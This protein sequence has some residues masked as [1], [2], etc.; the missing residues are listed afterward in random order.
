[1]TLRRALVFFEIDV[2]YCANTY[3]SAPCTASVPTT[4]ARKC[5]NSLGTCQDRGN[6]TNSP[7]TLRFAKDTDYLP[8]DIDI[9]SP[10]IVDVSFSAGT[11]SLG[12]DLGQRTSLT[13]KFKDHPHA[14]TGAGF[15]KYL[16]DRPY[17]PFKQGTFWG[18]FKARNP[19]LRGRACRLIMGFLGQSLAEMETRHFVMDSFSGPTQEGEFTIIAKDVLKLAD[20]ER[21]QAPKF[22][23]GTLAADISS[24]ASSL[25]VNPAGVGMTDYKASG[26]VAIGGK[27]IVAFTRG[28]T[29]NDANAQ[30]LLHFDGSN[31][32]TSTTDSSA[33]ARTMTRNGSAVLG[34]AQAKFGTASGEFPGT[35]GSHWSAADAAAWTFGGN[36]TLECHQRP[37]TLAADRTLLCHSTDINNMY[38]LYVTTTGRLRFEIVVSGVVTFSIQSATGIIVAATWAHVALVRN[39][40][41]WFLFKDGAIVATAN[42]SVSITNFTSTFKIGASGNGTSDLMLGYID[43]VRVSSIARWTAAFTVPDAQYVANGDVFT[44]TRAQF[45]TTA[46]AHSTEDRVQMCVAYSAKDPAEI[47]Y[48]LL[49]NY[50]DVPTAFLP[51]A[52]WQTESANYLG[53]VYTACIPYPV[54]VR[55]LLC[56]LIQQTASAMWWSDLDKQIRWQILRKIPAGAETYNEDVISEGTLNIEEQPD[57]RVSQCQVYFGQ[58]NALEPLEREDNYINSSL[59]ISLQTETDYGSPVIKTIFSRWIPRLG[60]AIAQRVGTI[61]LSRYEVPP[62]KATFELWRAEGFNRPILG[63]GAN[64]E[65]RTLQDDTGARLAAPIQI[66]RITPQLDRWMVEAE[67]ALF[68]AEELD[69]NNRIVP[70]DASG[71][72]L[73]LRTLHDSIYPVITNGTG[74]TVTCVIA[75]TVEIG[76]NSISLPAFDVGSWAA[77]PP[78]IILQVRG[79]VQGKGGQGLNATTSSSLAN[80]GTALKTR[81]AIQLDALGGKVWGGGGG[82][83]GFGFGG[84]GGAGNAVGGGAANSFGGGTPG[85]AGSKTA[86]G[87]GGTSNNIN[88]QGGTGGGPGL[89]GGS[90]F[91]PVGGTNTPGGSAGNAIDGISYVTVTQAGD[92][93][94]PEIN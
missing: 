65:D 33:N 21:S 34:T 84:G 15:D 83:G 1:M 70:I 41:D 39:G 44:I 5:F 93:R 79:T 53:R 7:V 75:S 52:D 43:E 2:D 18:K 71:F 50:A 66:T 24:G 60:K 19:Y 6:F 94:G 82:G 31:G 20:D 12:E 76:S 9:T 49:A 38:R 45:G 47:I 86:G 90:S 61:V 22:S 69:L 36:F 32:A 81:V 42:N 28:W 29:G 85:G 67:E 23:S 46:I 63:G 35:G 37:T 14:D 64:L 87:P 48:D 55:T 17:N 8:K 30:L 59:S 56:E 88:G 78:T 16:S 74:I 10:S 89:A 57:K 4:G 51:L 72:N 80:G 68:S 92:R 26:Y 54:G 3:G 40:N 73:N 58:R 77:T 27:E 91:E 11:I 25:Q 13:I 62:R